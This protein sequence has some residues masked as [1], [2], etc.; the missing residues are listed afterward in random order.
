MSLL[1]F[2]LCFELLCAVVFTLRVFFLSY[3]QIRSRIGR[4]HLR[5]RRVYGQHVCFVFFF[6][7]T[8]SV[9]RDFVLLFWFPQKLFNFLYV[10][11]FIVIWCVCIAS[12]WVN[13]FSVIFFLQNCTFH[14]LC[15]SLLFSIVQFICTCSFVIVIYFCNC[16]TF[17]QSCNLMLL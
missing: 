13:N 17:G 1:R 15:A 7:V 6:F 4:I 2:C 8:W 16:C 12:V 9:V 10:S 11:A 3:V 5:R 14:F